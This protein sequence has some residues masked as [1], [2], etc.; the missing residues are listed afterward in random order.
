MSEKL[1]I[2]EEEAVGAEVLAQA[3]CDVSA[4][5]KKLLSS[6]LSRRAIALLI[7]DRSGVSMADIDKVLDGAAELERAYVKKESR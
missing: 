4:A 2:I 3:I 6:R 5:A 1:R 7:K